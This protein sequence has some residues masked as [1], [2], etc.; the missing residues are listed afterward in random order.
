MNKTTKFFAAFAAVALM[1]ACSSEE[2]VVNGGEE[3]GAGNGQKAYLA[4]TINSTGDMGMGRSTDYETPVYEDGADFEHKVECVSFFF[5]DEQGN[6]VTSVEPD[7]TPSFGEDN[8]AND[9]IEY[10]STKN[11]L[12]LK[13][14]KGNKYPN[15]MLTVLNMGDFAAETT[16]EATTKK[17][18][19]YADNFKM[20]DGEKVQNFVMSTSAYFGE[21]LNHDNKYY[22][23]TKLH[24]SNFKLTADEAQNN[25]PVEVYVER[26]AAK[27][28][29]TVDAPVET[30]NGK[31]YFVLEQTIAGGGNNNGTPADGQANTKVYLEVEGWSLNAT[32]IDS[33][34]GKQLK[35][36]WATTNPFTAW[37]AVDRYRS[38]WAYSKAY[39][40][41]GANPDAHLNYTNLPAVKTPASLD[42]AEYCY[43]NTNAAENI[44]KKNSANQNLVVNS[45]VTHAILKT[46]VYNAAGEVQNLVE[47]RGVPYYEET[48][49]AY[50][51]NSFKNSS[52]GLNY[53]YLTGSKPEGE[54]T[55]TDYVQVDVK[56]IAFELNEGYEKVNIVLADANKALYKKTTNADGETE[57]VKLEGE[58]NDLATRLAAFQGDTPLI[59]HNQGTNI[60]F[61]PVEHNAT[62]ANKDKEGYYGVV[63]NHW[64]RLTVNS[65]SKL[66]H[67]A[68]DPDDATIIIKPDTPED[69]RYYVGAKIN[70]LSWRIISQ[71][72]DL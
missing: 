27:V 46:K 43:E 7:Y 66:G 31:E 1:S 34:V 24:E 69:P 72:V 36:D 40:E 64:Y 51:L 4:V 2:P 39:A 50:L 44:F 54:A 30:I 3:G 10:M 15:Y 5:F 45:K 18:S 6:L 61:I 28:Q 63:R 60:Y 42:Y 57:F 71:S 62:A 19:I 37:Q 11:I 53:Y 33:Y 70:I 29:L 9:N 58:D 20:Q 49:K 68:Y 17:L 65:F 12:V 25:S 48:F 8:P 14:I 23:V 22:N 38:F 67:G 32:A 56:D 16:L 21:N 13:D 59:W 35:A 41:G 47:Y 26:L 52:K 55:V